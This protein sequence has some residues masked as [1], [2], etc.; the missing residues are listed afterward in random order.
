M[1][2]IGPSRALCFV[3]RSSAA[4]KGAV[5]M[6]TS[7][8]FSE[9]YADLL[10]ASYDCVD[11]MVFNAFFPFGQTAGGIR[12]W[13]RWLHGNDLTQLAQNRGCAPDETRA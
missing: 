6:T 8:A 13:W 12:T 4:S 10:Q 3:A 11:R 5:D 7:D 9:Y 1:K 2:R